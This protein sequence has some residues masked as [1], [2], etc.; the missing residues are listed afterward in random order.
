MRRTPIRRHT[1]LR[2]VSSKQQ[3]KNTEWVQAREAALDRDQ[4]WPVC[5][6]YDLPGECGGGLHVHHLR[7]R[8]QG[9][10]HDLENLVTL[11]AWHHDWLHRNVAEAERL[12][13]LKRSVA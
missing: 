3:T 7:R 1:R 6:R 8:S 4:R 12:G 13:L 11:C 9:G 10:T 2:A 5:P